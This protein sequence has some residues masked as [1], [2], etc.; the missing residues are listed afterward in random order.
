MEVEFLSNMRYTLYASEDEWDAWHVK[1]GKFW[2]YFNVASQA[3]VER[4]QKLLNMPAPVSNDRPD[5]PSPPFSIQRTPPFATNSSF[6]TQSPFPPLGLSSDPY[7][8]QSTQAEVDYRNFGRKRSLDDP[9]NEYPAKRV[10]L[11][12]SES[13]LSTSTHKTPYAINPAMPRLPLPQLSIPSDIPYGNHH[14]SSPAHLPVPARTM[15]TVFSGSSR[16]P[17]NGALPSMQQPGQRPLQQSL[18]QSLQPSSYP[19]GGDWAGSATSSPSS[20]SFS[21]HTPTHPPASGYPIYRSSPYK[22]IRG[23]NTLLVPPS[24]ASLDPPQLL[25]YDQMQ[26]QPLGKPISERRV[27][28]LPYTY[29]GNLSHSYVPPFL[30][31][32]DIS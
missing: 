7:L 4:T 9:S 19:S 3:P 10:S 15:S 17:Q 14:A 11:A 21:Q 18:Q 1:L 6:N 29:H 23:V 24:S 30:P 13:S 27:G 16:W 8:S 25:G 2:K 5:L 31:H 12:P 26:Y 20:L 28:V 32:P 22:P